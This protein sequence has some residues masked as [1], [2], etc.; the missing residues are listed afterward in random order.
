VIVIAS[1]EHSG[2]LDGDPYE[3]VIVSVRMMKDLCERERADNAFLQ[4]LK[5]DYMLVFVPLI[6]PWGFD[7]NSYTNSNRV[8]LDRNYDTPGWGNDSDQRH[9]AYGGSENETQYFMNTLVASGAKIAVANHGLGPKV[10]T[11]TGE[12]V[13]AGMCAYMLGRDQDKYTAHL[14]G[15][16]EVMSCNYNLSLN[17]MNEAPAESYGKTR[18][19]MDWVG[20]EGGAVEMLPLEGFLL[21]GGKLHTALAEEAAYTLHLQFLNMLIECQAG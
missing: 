3:P 10:D 7:N 19:Y 20:V 13:S 4:M 9:G 21:H 16:A 6:N 11:N 8:N 18:S 5:N 17:N 15:I 2:Y 1:Q 14:N 12:A